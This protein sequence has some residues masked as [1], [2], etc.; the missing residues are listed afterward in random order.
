MSFASSLIFG[1]TGARPIATSYTVHQHHHHNYRNLGI[2][3]VL[4]DNLLDIEI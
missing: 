3:Q 4:L 2:F 1:A